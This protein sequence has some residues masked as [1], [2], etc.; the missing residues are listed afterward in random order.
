MKFKQYSFNFVCDDNFF[1]VLCQVH[2]IVK[3]VHGSLYSAALYIYMYNISVEKSWDVDTTYI[4]SRH[5]SS[6]S[7]V[8]CL[9]IL[10]GQYVCKV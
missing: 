7:A 8:L 10:L 3:G 2:V 9:Y 6:G 1:S 4:T 5:D